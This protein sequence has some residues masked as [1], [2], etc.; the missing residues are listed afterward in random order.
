MPPLRPNDIRGVRGD[1]DSISFRLSIPHW[2]TP[3]GRAVD[4]KLTPVRFKAAHAKDG[5]HHSQDDGDVQAA[6][7]VADEDVRGALVAVR[8]AQREE[9]HQRDDGD[10]EQH[11]A[12]EHPTLRVR[13]VHGQM[14]GRAPWHGGRACEQREDRMETSPSLQRSL[15]QPIPLCT[16]NLRTFC[17]LG[18]DKD[19]TFHFYL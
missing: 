3:L 8:L 17:R 11:D 6:L 18:Q 4:L 5:Q 19:L 15:C 10:D 7:H 16:G 14:V 9:Q 13:Q 2:D 12:Q 1:A